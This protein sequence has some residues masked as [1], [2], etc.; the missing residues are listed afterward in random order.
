MPAAQPIEA[1]D[2][3]RLEP[4]SAANLWRVTK[5][6]YGYAGA[7]NML[8]ANRTNWAAISSEGI[9]EVRY[10]YPRPQTDPGDNERR[11]LLQRGMGMFPFEGD[12][13]FTIAIESAEGIEEFMHEAGYEDLA[14]VAEGLRKKITENRNQSFIEQIAQFNKALKAEEP[15]TVVARLDSRKSSTVKK[16]AQLSGFF[17]KETTP[18]EGGLTTGVALTDKNGKLGGVPRGYKV[19]GIYVAV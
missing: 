8:R 2:P 19:W 17:L 10:D 16:I 7:H 3:A 18:E 11:E 13:D 15:G 6:D 14:V 9:L 1:I 12:V 5:V 4:L